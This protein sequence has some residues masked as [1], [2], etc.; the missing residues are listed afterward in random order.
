MLGFI[1]FFI[2]EVYVGTL[3]LNKTPKSVKTF[4]LTFFKFFNHEWTLIDTNDDNDPPSVAAATYSVAERNRSTLT[5][6]ERV[7]FNALAKAM[8]ALPSDTFAPSAISLCHR[9]RRSRSTSL[10]KQGTRE[11]PREFPITF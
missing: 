1:C 3:F 5:W 11:L 4:F 7:V 6:V 10:L 9:L 8:A 2:E